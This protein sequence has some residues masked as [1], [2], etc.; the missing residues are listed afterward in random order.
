MTQPKLKVGIDVDDV[1]LNTLAT[2]W[3]PEFNDIMN[4]NIKP[5]DI[6]EWDIAKFVPNIYNKA[7]YDVL[8]LNSTWDRVE[9]VKDSQEYL[10]RLNNNKNIELY[11]ISATS[12]LTT[13]R[14]WEKFFEYYPFIDPKQVVT[15]FNKQLLPKDMLMVDDK[16]DNLKMWDILFACPHNKNCVDMP[17]FRQLHLFRC[18]S[19]SQV[20]ENIIERIN[21]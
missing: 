14:K 16:F 7:I 10:R 5:S 17:R 12:V 18:N 15:M 11:I 6:T 1:L 9:P 20:Y 2:A 21:Y 8:G 3:L 13:N 4:M 19:W